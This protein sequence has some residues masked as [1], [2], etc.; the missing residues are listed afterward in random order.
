MGFVSEWIKALPT[1]DPGISTE[2]SWDSLLSFDLVS[3]ADSLMGKRYVCRTAG[4]IVAAPSGAGKSVWANHFTIHAGLGRPFFG[5]QMA[6][7]MRVTNI[8]AEDDLGDVAETVQS[9][10]REYEI[11]GEAHSIEAS[12]SDPPLERC[13]WRKILNSPARRRRLLRETPSGK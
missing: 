12:G 7:P 11:A 1:K 3:D 9:V 13:R 4:V 8:Q 6:F 5:L 10:V 2:M